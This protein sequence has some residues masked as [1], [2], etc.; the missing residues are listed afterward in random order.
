M[1]H[2]VTWRGPLVVAVVAFVG[3]GL[4]LALVQR[5]IT[6]S[7]LAVGGNPQVVAL[8]EASREDQRTLAADDPM[9]ALRHRERFGELDTLLRRL[10]ILDHSRGDIVGRYQTILLALSMLVVGLVVGTSAVRQNR[11][12]KR[13]ARL[14]QALEDLAAGRTDVDLGPGRRDVIGRVEAMVVRTSRVMARDRRRIEGLRNL[15]SWQEAARRHAHEMRTP[16]TGARLELARL[17][18]LAVALEATAPE[19]QA[20]ALRRAAKSALQELERLRRFTQAFTSFA[21][22]PKARLVSLDLY[23]LADEFVATFADA[24]PGVRLVPPSATS[25][26]DSLPVRADRDLIRQ[27][28]VNLCDNAA[29][30][31][32]E[33]GGVVR[34]SLI[35]HDDSDALPAVPVNTVALDVSDDGPGIDPALFDRLFE[36]YTTTRGVGEGMGLGLAISRKLML[37]QDGDLD[38]LPDRGHGATFRLTLP[39]VPSSTHPSAEHHSVEPGDHP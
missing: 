36:P 29:L 38:V 30:A 5:R 8:L 17:E 21:R 25:A 1:S 26:T 2:V 39:C 7:L 23:A 10:R 16:L 4:V 28:L 18:D 15:S 22:L 32:D 37:D 12:A 6:S 3:A 19:H 34:L 13:L 20:A 31:M 35:T 9:A 14:Q 11:R 24:W 27:V 33:R